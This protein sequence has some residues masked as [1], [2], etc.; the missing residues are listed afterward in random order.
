MVVV[1]LVKV[2]LDEDRGVD[3][4]GRL[5]DGVDCGGGGAVEGGEGHTIV[6]T[7]GHQFDQII[8]RDHTCRHQTVKTHLRNWV[9]YF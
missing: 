5:E 1:E 8:S 3:V 7:V 2:Y 9:K 4:P 6:A